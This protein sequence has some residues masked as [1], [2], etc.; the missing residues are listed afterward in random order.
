MDLRK[1]FRML[2]EARD[3]L[4][5]PGAYDAL[6]AK[7][8]QASGFQA[9]YM[10]GY[11]QSA[12]KLGAPDVGL[13]SMAEMTE[14][15]RDMAAAV[16]IPVACDADTGFGNIVNVIRTVRAYEQA[17][18]AAIQLEDQVMPKKCGH[19]LGRQI[20]SAE[21]MAEKIRGAVAARSDP[22]FLIIARTDART[23]Y[24]IEEAIRRGK[25]YE[26]SG[27]DI[28]F[29]ESL[30]SAEEMKRINREMSKPTVANMVEGGRSPFLSA[31]ELQKIGYSLVLY[32]VSTL[33]AAA[34]GVYDLLTA[35]KETGTTEG[36]T[37]RMMGFME[38]NNFI[39]LSE[40]QRIE[41]GDLQGIRKR[42]I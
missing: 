28:I 38:F 32:P 41:V 17:G 24:G 8:V 6:S 31:Q 34:K 40:I 30:E 7:L 1:Q 10:T 23:T 3:I 27:A 21:E 11:G 16:T 36:F 5:L 12:S 14:R 35:L 4:V 42:L 18:A 29:V 37:D 26:E 9:V 33:Y 39:G 20:I 25:L 2:V 15:V 13:L 19:M 22:D